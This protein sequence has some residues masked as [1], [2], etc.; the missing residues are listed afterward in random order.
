MRTLTASLAA[1]VT[2][3]G[4][5]SAEPQEAG[6]GLLVRIYEV[7]PGLHALPELASGQLPNEVLVVPT[8]DL[9]PPAA[10]FGSCRDHFVTEVV[11]HVAVEGP[12]RYTFR[13]ISD[14]GAR[15]WIDGALVVDHDGL[16]GAV[17]KDGEVE[18]APGRHALRVLHFEE[19][20]EERLSL[21][22]RRFDAGVESEFHLIPAASLSHDPSAPRDTAPGIKKIIPPLRRGLPGDGTPVGRL[23]P[24]FGSPR[25][26]PPPE[27]P[28]VV[29]ALRQ[30]S[31]RGGFLWRMGPPGPDNGWQVVAWVPETGTGEGAKVYLLH[32]E[33]YPGHVF[34]PG[35]AEA[36]R[37][38]LDEFDSGRNAC[39]F[40]FGTNKPHQLERSSETPFEMRTVLEM[41]NGIEIRFTKPLD[42]RC[43]W[44]PESYYVEQWPFA[45]GSDKSGLESEP[46]KEA[47]DSASASAVCPPRRDGHRYPVKSASVS[48]DRTRVFLEIP[49]LKLSHVVYIRLL[50]P[51]YSEDG[52]RLWS[53]E[54]WYT[55]NAIPGARYGKVLPPPA[56]EPQ[57]VLTAEETA[58]G[59]KLLF[60]GR[61][62]HGWRGYKKDEFP[63]GW[64]VRD[65]CLVRVGPGGDIMTEAEFD[66]FELKIEW[67]ISAAG[68]SGIFYR[69]DEKH[70]WPWETGPEMQVLD[71]AEHADGR[72]PKTSAGSNYALYAPVQDVTQPVGF[73][74]QARIVVAGAHV[75]HW[76]NGVKVV[77]YELGSPD[78]QQR[79]AA[80]KFSSMPH[81]GRMKKGHIVL[82][83][84][85]DQVW[86]RNIK[87][88]PLTK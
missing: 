2:A 35:L 12:G 14:D 47:S 41:M 19:G 74:N 53:T 39:A 24:G 86:Y 69:V 66:N 64:V 75:E 29:D 81:Y 87:F 16:H 79:V 32:G 38:F 4:L 85:G 27:T 25:R 72:N 7:A 28:E 54:A 33:T 70:G 84:H 51:C 52:E 40:R 78:W 8:L 23:H 50:P 1:F 26:Y 71:N 45:S 22:W 58:A 65:G 67:R 88:R 42:P 36:K 82:Q 61:T 15:L 63:D 60:D 21:H 3:V 73:F 59:W 43:G 55:L 48:A 9:G 20:G 44:D 56:K 83:D 62:T 77:A 76:L 10:P 80:S 13:L 17:P 6:P 5:S 30:Y 34:V 11:G 31:V 46:R 18:L 49:D 57:N 37:V 68:N